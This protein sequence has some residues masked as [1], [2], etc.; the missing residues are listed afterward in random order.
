MKNRLASQSEAIELYLLKPSGF[1]TAQI[2]IYMQSEQAMS[3]VE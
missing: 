2:G 3:R 1:C